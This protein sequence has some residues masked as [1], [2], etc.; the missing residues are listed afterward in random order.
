[1]KNF[2][3][4]AII[5]ILIIKGNISSKDNQNKEEEQLLFVYEHC[6]HGARAPND[7]K[8]GLYNDKTKTDSYNIYWDKP[9]ILTEY[10]KL[11]HFFIGLRNKYKYNNLINFSTYNKNEILL[12]TTGVKRCTESLYYQLLGMYYNENLNNNYSIEFNDEIYKYS[13]PPNIKNWKNDKIFFK[14]NN[15]IKNFL[16]NKKIEGV[17]L[18]SFNSESKKAFNIKTIKNNFVFVTQKCKNHEKYVKEQRNKYKEII[19]KNFIDNN[20]SNKLKKSMSFINDSYLY[21]RGI[22]KSLADHFI[23]DYL[24]G[25]KELNEFSK[26][27]GINLL[28]YYKKCQDVYFYFM[29][30]IYCFSKSCVLIN[31]K[32]KF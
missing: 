7:K 9:G 28:D 18:T 2:L 24:I 11:Q 8:N 13:M 30:N 25:R 31:I 21:K 19:K 5:I 16:K 15:T 1:M 14:I 3:L 32:L 17:N 22:A 20:Y 26:K 4:S 12:R 29:Y 27:T 6:R 23:S 10:G